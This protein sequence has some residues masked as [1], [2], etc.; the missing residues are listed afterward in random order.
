MAESEYRVMAALVP[1]LQEL[2][3][4][5]LYHQLQCFLSFIPAFSISPSILIRINVWWSFSSGYTPFCFLSYLC[6]R[7]WII[8]HSNGLQLSLRRPRGLRL[9]LVHPP[10]A[11]PRFLDAPSRMAARSIHSLKRQ[12]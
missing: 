9:P 10:Y 6:T 12:G 7:S 1:A 2:A 4:V 5:C 3:L 11:S 8:L